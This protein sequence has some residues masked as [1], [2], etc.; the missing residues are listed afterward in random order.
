MTFSDPFTGTQYRATTLLG[1]G[2]MGEVYEVEHAVTGVL[3]AAKVLLPELAS[4]EPL[5]D[6]MRVEAQALG[7]LQH[8]NIVS[9]TDF[10]RTGDGRPFY[11][12]Q[13]LQGHTVGEELEARGS[14]SVGDAVDIVRQLLRALSAAHALGLVHRDV[15]ADNLFLHEE[16]DG[17][18][19]VK[20]LDFGVTKVLPGRSGAEGGVAPPM[21]PTAD[22]SVVDTP[23]FLSP[24]Q[25]RGKS[26]D[27][28]ADIYATGLL[29]YILI[30]GRGPFDDARGGDRAGHYFVAHLRE[31]PAPPSA[32]SRTTLPPGLDDVVLRALRK[33]PDDRFQTAEEFERALAQLGTAR[34]PAGAPSSVG[35]VA[36]LPRGTDNTTPDAAPPVLPSLDVAWPAGAGPAMVDQ[37]GGRGDAVSLATEELPPARKYVSPTALLTTHSAPPQNGGDGVEATAGQI[38]GDTSPARRPSLAVWAVAPVAATITALAGV[39]LSGDRSAVWLASILATSVL[40]AAIASWLVGRVSR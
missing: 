8:P 4:V 13:R 25:I 3:M 6:R 21:V 24:E 36:P 11:V 2:G 22:G 18:R 23:R 17:S 14:L 15:K 38:A 33:N 30:C 37:P 31:V 39:G 40:V 16:P 10:A 34:V 12:M 32:F 1:R 19:V 29:L 9:V 5:A 27:H 28:R 26:I 20:V 7:R 35:I